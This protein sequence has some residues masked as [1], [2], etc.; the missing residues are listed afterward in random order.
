MESFGVFAVMPVF[1]AGALVGVIVT[2]TAI[3]QL[4]LGIKDGDQRAW[5]VAG[6]CIC[7]LVWRSSALR[8]GVHG[9]EFIRIYRGKASAWLYP[10]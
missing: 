8:M 9:P 2:T 5:R 10:R 4:A 7:G 3:L 6:W 1:F